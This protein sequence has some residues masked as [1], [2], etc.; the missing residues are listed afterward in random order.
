MSTDARSTGVWAK[1]ADILGM[2]RFSHTLFALPFALLGAAMA[3][4]DPR[5]GADAGPKEWIGILLCMVTARSAAMAFNRLV[6]RR[7]DAN[8]PRTAT[9][10]LPSGRLS[11]R[12]VAV[13]TVVN[14]VLFI[15]ATALF[16]PENRWPMV[17]SVPVLLWLLGYSYAKRFTSLAHY[18]L[19][20]ALA[21][22]PIA[23]W[24]AL[25]GDLDWPPVL[26]G[27]V[28]LCWV[29]G[30]DII[31]ACQ[32]AGFDRSSGLR[33]I[34]SRL[35]IAGAL[36]LAAASHAA[37][38]AA[39]VALGLSVPAFGVIYWAGVAVVAALLVYEH[40][41]VRPSD[42]GRVN[43]A[44]F[45]VNIGISLGLLAVGVVDLLV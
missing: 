23:A 2:I 11:V 32:D 29:G 43:V 15:G 35:G 6:D 9:R 14:A 36:R 1:L 33:S 19:G 17:L 3:V 10:H 31:Y 28:V 38:V 39:L 40:A 45:Q 20:A 44:F 26:L 7:I 16:L 34:P 30:F 5:G 41:I 12:S 4:L 27:V 8:N 42:L 21:M 24:I 22:A 13:F 25:R 37:M 18:W